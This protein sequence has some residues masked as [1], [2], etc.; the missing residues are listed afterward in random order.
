[1]GQ[2]VAIEGERARDRLAP[3]LG[4]GEQ[5]VEGRFD[6]MAPGVGGTLGLQM[7]EQG[8]LLRRGLLPR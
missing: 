2:H 1:M 5:L 8:G 7:V 6:E 4:P 3:R